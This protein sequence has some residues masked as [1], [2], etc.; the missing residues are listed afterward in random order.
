MDILDLA[1]VGSGIGGSLIASLNKDKD[2]ILFE[3]DKNLGGAASTFKKNGNYY[4][5]GATTFVGYEDNHVVK[6]IFDSIGVVPNISKSNIA[7]RVIQNGSVIDRSDDFFSFLENIDR[8]Y[9]NKNNRI[10]WEKLNQIDKQFWTLKDIYY[11]KYSLKRYYKT[12]LFLK[13]LF[14]VFGFDLLKSAEGFIKEI[15]GDIS[16]DYKHFINAQLLITIQTTSKDISLLSMALGLCYPFHSVYYVNGGMGELILD[17]LKDV[18]VKKNEEVLKIKRISNGWH[19][20]TNKNE[21]DA[22]NVVL[23]S[24]IYQSGELFEDEKI[25]K[26]YNS[27]PF[28]D[29]SAFVIYLTIRSEDQFLE[30]Y[31]FINN[32]ILINTISN[33][34]F[35]SCS[36]KTDEKLSKNGY[37][38]TVSTHTKALFWKN[39]SS[40]EYQL[41][42]EETK[43]Q[44]MEHFFNY[45]V[46]VSKNDIV[47]IFT[48]TSL[49]F[50]R[51]INRYNCGGKAIGIKNIFDLPSGNTP[52]CGLYNV[53]DTVFAGQGWPGISIGVDVLNKELRG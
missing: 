42:K 24:T 52:F 15:L 21:Y 29:Q 33:S 18:E 43:N 31:Q 7:I 14:S 6:N 26:Y 11:G 44:I 9:P 50:N 41:K 49:T 17:I 34:F 13:E 39:L 36:K 12:S 27:F 5:T 48:A 38:L 2:T 10:F 47:D 40:S 4:N 1:I 53:G 32:T 20:K 45:F 8:I 51:Y 22:K 23:N 19:I 25:K 37:S 16:Q 28:S 30:H 35:V 46:G 3:K